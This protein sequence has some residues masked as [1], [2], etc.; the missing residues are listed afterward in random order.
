[1]ASIIAS[2]HV[3]PE[4]PMLPFQVEDTTPV[5]DREKKKSLV[6]SDAI[7]KANYY[8]PIREGACDLANTNRDQ[9]PRVHLWVGR[10]SPLPKRS[11]PP[12]RWTWDHIPEH[13]PR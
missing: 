4:D 11:Q 13:S 2:P 8:L 9:R 5:L 10:H 7:R 1:M 12:S 3:T 6:S